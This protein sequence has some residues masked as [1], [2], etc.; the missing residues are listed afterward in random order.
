MTE[1]KERVCAKEYTYFNIKEK[2][3]MWLMATCIF[4][5]FAVGVYNLSMVQFQ[6]SFG[7]MNWYAISGL[8]F[9]GISINMFKKSFMEDFK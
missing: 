7:T 8:L 3:R 2:T 4:I 5:I 9:I 1:T 6:E